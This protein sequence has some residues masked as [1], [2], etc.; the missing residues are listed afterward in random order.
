[1]SI[2]SAAQTLANP[3]VTASN[4]QNLGVSEEKLES[5]STAPNFQKT[6]DEVQQLLIQS[7]KQTTNLATGK[8]ENIHEAMIA[9][10]KAETAVK[11]LVQIRNKALEAYNEILKMQV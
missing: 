3:M 10:E 8:A 7:D 5:S 11:L 9:T 2:L 4:A 1:M 6:L